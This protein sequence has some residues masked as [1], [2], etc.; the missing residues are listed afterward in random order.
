[1]ERYLPVFTDLEQFF[2]VH[3]WIK[4]WTIYVEGALFSHFHPPN[5]R[6]LLFCEEKNNNFLRLCMLLR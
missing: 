5:L 1:M 6:K 4:V 3:V 2:Q